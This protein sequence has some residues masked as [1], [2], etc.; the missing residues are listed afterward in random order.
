MCLN[1]S[2]TNRMCFKR[3]KR[4]ESIAHLAPHYEPAVCPSS[5]MRAWSHPWTESRND[6]FVVFYRRVWF[7][8]LWFH[9]NQS[10]MYVF[11]LES[12]E[13]SRQKWACVQGRWLIHELMSGQTNLSRAGRLLRTQIWRTTSVACGCR[14]WVICQFMWP[15]IRLMI[16]TEK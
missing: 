12:N 3:G 15:R 5:C 13:N 8:L 10:P 6:M 2:V 1:D 4:I 9:D 11:D 14:W 7:V 16:R